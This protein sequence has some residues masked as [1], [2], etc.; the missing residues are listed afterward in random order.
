MATMEEILKSLDVD[1]SGLDDGDKGNKG[2]DKDKVDLANIDLEKIPEEHRKVVK[3]LMDQSEEFRNDISKR[4]IVIDTLKT[5]AS[6]LAQQYEK[7]K[8]T[9]KQD[10]PDEKILG[11]IEKD[12]PHAP[13]FLA[14]ANQ[15]KTLAASNAA[16]NEDNFAKDVVSFAEKNKDMFQYAKDMDTILKEHPTLRN[17]VPKLYALAKTINERRDKK[18]KTGKQDLDRKSN[19]LRFT[20][21]NSGMSSENVNDLPGAKTIGEAF[22]ISVATLQKRA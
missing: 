20:T 4:D 1:M 14:L 2:D 5:T 17:D 11:V 19:A 12:D 10:D 21:E 9:G 7:D 15:V 6:T 18:T 16:G 8:K 22:D 3:G 13:A